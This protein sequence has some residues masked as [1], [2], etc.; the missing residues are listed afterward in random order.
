[1]CGSERKRRASGRSGHPG[2][3]QRA[4]PRQDLPGGIDRQDKGAG[5]VTTIQGLGGPAPARG[6]RR[7]GSAN[8]ST[9]HVP[10]DR[11]AAEGGGEGVAEGMAAEGASAAMLDAML[12]LQEMDPASERDRQGRRHGQA[13]LA[14]LAGLQS[15]LLSAAGDDEAAVSH[16]TGL[17]A[18]MPV[19]AD[20]TLNGVLKA[21]RVRA[22]VE[23]ARRG[24]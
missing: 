20:P 14:A 5:R 11:T 9:F 7:T 21:I 8:G 18:Q 17:L 2:G 3:G 15:A 19:A 12:S 1:M 22:M 4:G 10:P 24:R 16:L 6:G 23:L 13:M